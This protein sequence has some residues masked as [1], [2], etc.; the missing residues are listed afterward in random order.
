[1]V[2]LSL[3]WLQQRTVRRAPEGSGLARRNRANL[4]ALVIVM[5]MMAIVFS[6]AALTPVMTGNGALPVFVTLLVLLAGVIAIIWL[7]AR[8]SAEPDDTPADTTPDEC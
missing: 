3:A 7:V 6:L 8:A 5:W 4:A 1:M 2:L